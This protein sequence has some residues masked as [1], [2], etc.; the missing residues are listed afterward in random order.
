MD[1]NPDKLEEPRAVKD[2]PSEE[3]KRRANAALAQMEKSRPEVW[4]FF[5]YEQGLHSVL[6]RFLA[7]SPFQGSPILM[8]I[9]RELARLNPDLS[10]WN[11]SQLRREKQKAITDELI[12]KHLDFNPPHSDF[13]QTRPEVAARRVTWRALVTVLVVLLV[14]SP[15]III[16]QETFGKGLSSRDM[17]WN[18]D[19]RL[20]VGEFFHAFDVGVRDIQGKPCREVYALKDGLPVRELCP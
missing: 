8:A 7:T 17:D 18:D 13:E 12:S 16:A 14:G 11:V 20:S 15:L 1:D 9:E 5:L 10:S 19:G 4:Y 6:G 3:L 2:L